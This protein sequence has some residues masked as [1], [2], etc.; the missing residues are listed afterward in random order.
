LT[1]CTYSVLTK[2]YLQGHCKKD[3]APMTRAKPKPKPKSR[4]NRTRGEFV[5]L[6]L[7]AEEKRAVQDAAASVAMPT[8]VWIRSEILKLA[9]R[10]AKG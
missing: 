10:Q 9:R 1:W 4:R 5:M 3:D 2:L 7:T 6:M 8:S